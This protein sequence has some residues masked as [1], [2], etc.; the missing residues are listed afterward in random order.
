VPSLNEYLGDMKYYIDFYFDRR[1]GGVEIVG[2]VTKV[3]IPA[4]WKMAAEQFAGDSYH[5]QFTHISNFSVI[6]PTERR[7]NA[8][9][10]KI[11]NERYVMSGRQF[12]SPFGHGTGFLNQRGMGFASTGG[13]PIID[14]YEA[15]ILPEI[16]AR[17]GAD[18]RHMNGLHCTVFPNFSWLNPARTLRVWHPKGPDAFEVWSFAFVDK[19]APEDVKQAT[20]WVT[21]MQFGPTGL[22]EQDDGENWGLISGNLAGRG[23]QVHKMPLNYAMGLGHEG[24][25]PT[26]PGQVSPHLFGESAQRMFYRRW[27]EFMTS[28]EWP[29][30]AELTK[31]LSN[32]TH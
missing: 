7:Q 15:S 2:G 31:S 22:A 3:K 19:Q 14:A 9:E 32:G 13:D 4:N 30:P 24:L 6:A 27:A 5:A 8:E 17:L 23:P 10:A 12:T 21:Q 28:A 1:E 11:G 16:E 26:F 25:D 18:R 20:R 29:V